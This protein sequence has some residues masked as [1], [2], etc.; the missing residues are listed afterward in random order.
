MWVVMAWSRHIPSPS[1]SVD[2]LVHTQ[3]ADCEIIP[4][5]PLPSASMYVLAHICYGT[6]IASQFLIFDIMSEEISGSGN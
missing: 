6:M 2:A 3:V 4:Y 5:I 1:V